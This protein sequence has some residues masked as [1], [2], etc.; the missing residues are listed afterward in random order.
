MIKIKRILIPVLF[1]LPMANAVFAQRS[2]KDYLTH[3]IIVNDST[4]TVIAY[5]KPGNNVVVEPD[6]FYHW[7][8]ASKIKTTQGGY[9][10]KL[11][12]GSY[13]DYYTNKNLKELGW[14]KGGLKYAKWKSW[15]DTG[16]LKDEYSWDSGKKNG[17]YIKYDS[18]GRIVEK[19]KYRNDLLNG[20][21]RIYAGDNVKVVLYKDGK[22]TEP[23]P[24]M[25]KFIRKIFAKKSK[26]K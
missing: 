25:P 12:N 19:G 17:Q 11:L 20:K 5:V 1:C 14:F 21:Q 16:K 6:R 3:K 24:C 2:V 9:S 4:H 22:V 15:T 23:K 18:L 10:G 26:T 8:S 13:Q 7:F